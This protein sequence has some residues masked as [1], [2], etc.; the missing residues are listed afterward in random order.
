MPRR[1]PRKPYTGVL[2]ERLPPPN[3]VSKDVW[4]RMIAERDRALFEHYGINPRRRFNLDDPDPQES[5]I[6]KLQQDHV[7]GYQVER[8]PGHKAE[9]DRVKQDAL[10]ITAFFSA[11]K[12]GQ[13][14]RKTAESLAAEEEVPVSAEAA[15]EVADCILAEREVPKSLLVRRPGP[16]SGMTGERIRQRPYELFEEK[17]EEALL[18]AMRWWAMFTK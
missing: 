16:L 7:T 8:A 18:A 6:R 9:A 11:K 14:W 5:L 15:E 1:P 4:Y 17:N 13:S 3:S 12:R 10:I 2:L